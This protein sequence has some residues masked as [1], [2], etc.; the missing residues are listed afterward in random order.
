MQLELYLKRSMAL[1]KKKLGIQ[2]SLKRLVFSVAQFYDATDTLVK[3]RVAHARVKFACRKGCSHC[4]H[5]RVELLPPEVFYIAEHIKTL[6]EPQQAAIK[7][8]LAL[9]NAY[10]HNKTFA[11]YSKACPFLTAQSG[12]ALYAVR[13]HKC[14]AMVSKRVETCIVTGDAD[15]DQPLSAA[16]QQLVMQTIELYKQQG[17]VMH[18]VELGQGLLA[19][20]QNEQLAQRW[21]M[22]EQV[23]DLLPEKIVFN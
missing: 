21:H 23:F 8:N 10:A 17:C 18:P 20:L 15:E 5:L 12:C 3:Q 11:E 14:R 16:F 9:H 19:A 22:G 4:C 13:P 6:P 2:P 1:W 7:N